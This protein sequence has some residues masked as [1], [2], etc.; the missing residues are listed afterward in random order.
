MWGAVNTQLTVIFFKSVFSKYSW[1]KNILGEKKKH[2]LHIN[3]EWLLT[4]RSHNT[5]IL[6][7]S[8]VITLHVLLMTASF[9]K[10]YEYGRGN[11]V[12]ASVWPAS[13]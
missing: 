3:A 11:A 6:S 9:S 10:G 4:S 1:G 8:L 13:L 7:L 2:A 5:G 12:I